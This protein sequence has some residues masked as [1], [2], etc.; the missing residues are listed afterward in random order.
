MLVL[1]TK[2][3]IFRVPVNKKELKIME[4]NSWRIVRSESIEEIGVSKGERNVVAYQR[5]VKPDGR[6]Y[7]EMN[8]TADFLALY[9]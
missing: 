7:P 5:D 2:F 1:V 3:D 8:K 4:S 9:N 6:V